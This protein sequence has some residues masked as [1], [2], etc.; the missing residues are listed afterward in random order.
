MLTSVVALA[1]LT[2]VPLQ[3]SDLQARTLA[4]INQLR[5]WAGLPIARIDP[6]LA[7]AAQSHARY[8]VVNGRIGHGQMA[9][10][11]GFSGSGPTDRAK[12]FGYPGSVNEGTGSAS[13]PELVREFFSLLY[14]RR[15]LTSPSTLDIGAGSAIWTPQDGPRP[16]SL[17]HGGVIK[18]SNPD[19]VAGVVAYP[20]PG[21]AKAGLKHGYGEIPNPLA[22]HRGAKLPAGYP[23]TIYAVR[24]ASRCRGT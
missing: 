11:R 13:G 5:G 23:V 15:P 14:H 19:A 3:D 7:Q 21:Q 16:Q 9:G 2:S 10:L 20:G 8:L 1:S 6:R 12:A 17:G 18:Y 4:Q 22:P 24:T